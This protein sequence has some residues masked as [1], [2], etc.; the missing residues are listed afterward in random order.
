M[1]VEIGKYRDNDK[2]RKIKVKI[3]KYDTWSMDH[4]LA[5]I[6]LPMLKQ[7]KKSKHGAPNTDDEDVPEELRSTSAPE[8]ENEYDVDK[9]HFKRWNWIM[10]EM[11]FAFKHIV[12]KND[13]ESKFCSGEP[14]WQ[15]K[16]SDQTFYNPIT[17]KHENTFEMI[18]GPNHTFEMD[19][20][21][22]KAVNDRI[23]NGLRLF[24]KYY[25]GLWD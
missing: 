4:T 14:D 5:Y 3:H 2:K 17:K 12:D 16:K 20:E 24:G 22:I 21:G 8:K 19:I 1:K 9:N 18:K 7:L 11:I 25:R 15:W 6:V 23:D 13:W 10:D